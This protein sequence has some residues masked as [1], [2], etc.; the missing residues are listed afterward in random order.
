MFSKDKKDFRYIGADRITN[1]KS[2][3]RT[4]PQPATKPGGR[5]RVQAGDKGVSP[6]KS[7]PKKRKN[8][9][10]QEQTGL[11]MA[12]VE[13]SEKTYHVEDLVQYHGGRFPTI[14][15]V[16]S[17]YKGELDVDYDTGTV[18]TNLLT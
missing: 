16:T 4:A 8:L 11:S 14:V 12:A 13:W 6:I 2:G 7:K 18:S 10:A 5:V 1:I 3:S 17:G 9:T 15:K